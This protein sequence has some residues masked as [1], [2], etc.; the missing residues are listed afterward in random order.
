MENMQSYYFYQIWPC[1][2]L[3]E[4]IANLYNEN[5]DLPDVMNSN[6]KFDVSLNETLLSHTMN[7][8]TFV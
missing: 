4:V 8:N 7:L 5:A 3:S 6:R 2:V 1:L